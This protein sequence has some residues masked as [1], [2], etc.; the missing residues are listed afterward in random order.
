MMERNN[1]I[2]I[3]IPVY[4]TEKYIKETIESILNQNLD[5]FELILVD[6]GSQDNSLKILNQ[7]ECFPNVKV[8]HQKNKGAPSARNY[9]LSQAT[10][11]YIL[12]FDSDDVIYSNSLK[13]VMQTINKNNPDLV[14]MNYDVVDQNQ[15]LITEITHKKIKQDNLLDMM[16]LTPFPGNKI[17]KKEIIDKNNIIFDSVKIAQDLNF[18]LKY[19][20]Y[21]KHTEFLNVKLT[22]YRVID[23]SVSHSFDIRILDIIKSFNYI[24]KYYDDQ[25]VNDKIFKCLYMTKLK[26]L[27]AQIGKLRGKN[28]EKLIAN[29]FNEISIEIKETL[30]KI[31]VSDFNEVKFIVLYILSYIKARIICK[32]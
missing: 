3:I 27:V 12:F 11:D 5:L 14:I 21:V 4:N 17:Y 9:G 7:Y 25:N 24:E 22:K 23:N 32:I 16:C 15:N 20:I 2:S 19:L 1:K 10:G 13:L 31:H 18:Y 8:L 26:H 30:K 6:D 28:D 29:I